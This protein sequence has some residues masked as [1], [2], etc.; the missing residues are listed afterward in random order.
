[1]TAGLSLLGPS[2]KVK[3]LCPYFGPCGGCAY[4][5]LAYEDELSLKEE[6]LKD[7]LT[8][9]PGLAREIFDP[10]VP[11]PSPYAYR[12]RLDLSLRRLRGR[13]SIGFNSGGTGQLVDIESCAIARPEINAFLPALR[14]LATER[15]PEDYRTA[16]LVVKTGE[17]G[18]IRWGGIGRGSLSLEEPEYLWTEI[19]GKKI[20]YSLDTFFQANL[21]ILPALMQTLRGLLRL[22]P[23]TS[24]LDLYSGVGLFWTVFAS[25]ARAVWAVEESDSAVRVAEF[26]RRYHGLSSVF[27]HQ[28]RAED[29]LEKILAE[30]QR[31]PQAAI[32]DPPRQGFSPQA[33]AVLARATSLDPLIYISCNPEA[34]ARD[35][36]GFLRSGWKADRVV[37]FDFFPK[38]R[39][40]EAVVRLRPGPA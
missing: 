15:L 34:L 18:G 25:K 4:Q 19:E 10:I 1:M 13:V 30:I 7:L 36:E 29:C 22:T 31:R 2:P 32:A 8:K 33:L 24:L 16:N 21:A 38:T 37:P 6:N 12:S 20:F 17:G 14:R 3:P 26:N 40:L 11:S 27:L 28:A 23:E 5:D 39:H 9:R 35:L